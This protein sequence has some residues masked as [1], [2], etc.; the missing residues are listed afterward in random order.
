MFQ[1][2]FR[3]PIASLLLV[4]GSAMNVGSRINDAYTLWT[5][6]LPTQVWEAIG[7]AIFFLAVIALLYRWDKERRGS[8]PA[9]STVTQGSDLAYSLHPT[10]QA[11]HVGVDKTKKNIQIGFNLQN[12]SDAPLRY[13]V[14][15][16]ASVVDGRAAMK[17]NFTNKGG[18]VPRGGQT[19]FLC[20]PIP[21]T[22]TKKGAEA[23]ASIIY[24]YGPAGPDAPSVREAVYRYEISIGPTGNSVYVV[25]EE[26][27]AQI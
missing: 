13:T 12:A 17:Q 4:V 22:L 26:N 15:E 21:Y 24:Q 20:A 3:H 27:D 11:V 6:G 7:A 14:T 19:R 1:F 25:R 10:A 2:L 8:V 18:V 9:T 23:T 5:T 16:A